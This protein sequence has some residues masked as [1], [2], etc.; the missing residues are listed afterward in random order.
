MRYLILYA[1]EDHGTYKFYV[2]N[3]ICSLNTNIQVPMEDTAVLMYSFIKFIQNK[4]GYACKIC[5]RLWFEGNLKN[6]IHDSVEFVRT[7]LENVFTSGG[8]T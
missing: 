1:C 5:D 3:C 4:L 7:F 2:K 6:L 8:W